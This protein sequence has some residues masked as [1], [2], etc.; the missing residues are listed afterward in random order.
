[1][2]RDVALSV[3]AVVA[4]QGD[5]CILAHRLEPYYMSSCGDCSPLW[6]I[7]MSIRRMVIQ[8]LGIHHLRIAGL[9]VCKRFQWAHRL[10]AKVGAY[11]GY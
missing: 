11:Y 10:G 8:V 4:V 6:W 9:R 3:I 5:L 2:A 1:M 7:F